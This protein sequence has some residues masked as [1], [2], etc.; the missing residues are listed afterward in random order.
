MGENIEQFEKCRAEI[1]LFLHSKFPVKQDLMLRNFD[2]YNKDSQSRDIFFGTI[3]FLKEN[4]TISVSEQ[5]YGGFLSVR[6][7]NETYHAMNS[8]PKAGP[9]DTPLYKRMGEALTARAYDVLAAIIKEVL[10]KGM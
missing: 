8:I 2:E 1:L 5:I 6:L 3:D 7:S 9:D 10:T 4:S